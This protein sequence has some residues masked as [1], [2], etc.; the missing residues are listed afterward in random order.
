VFRSRSAHVFDQ[1]DET[2]SPGNAIVTS[3]REEQPILTGCAALDGGNDLD[4]SALKRAPS[5]ECQIE[6]I[7][8]GNNIATEPF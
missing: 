3:M 8:T 5:T 4:G 2:L 1:S 6:P 7:S